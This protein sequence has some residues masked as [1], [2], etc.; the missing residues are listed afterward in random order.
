MHCGVARIAYLRL[1]LGGVRE[2]HRG[3]AP[4]PGPAGM[5]GPDSPARSCRYGRSGPVW[6]VRTVLTVLGRRTVRRNR[7][8]VLAQGRKQPRRRWGRGPEEGSGGYPPPRTRSKHAH[9]GARQLPRVN[10]P[11][12]QTYR[13]LLETLGKE[14][15]GTP[16]GRERIIPV[17]G[18][19]SGLPV[20]LCHV[21][22]TAHVRGDM[23]RDPCP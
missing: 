13:Y 23:D 1:P 7:S 15:L 21:H 9:V 3:A 20:V 5:A 22:H 10:E 8:I 12:F 19:L 11:R 18:P 17:L 16:S 2:R 4:L 14:T 6:P